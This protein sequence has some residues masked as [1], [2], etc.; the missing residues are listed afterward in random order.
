MIIHY[1]IYIHI[2]YLLLCAQTLHIVLKKVYKRSKTKKYIYYYIN[3]YIYRG[4]VAHRQGARFN[5]VA[6]DDPHLH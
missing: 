2:F 4:P 5:R 3:I 1:I 6:A